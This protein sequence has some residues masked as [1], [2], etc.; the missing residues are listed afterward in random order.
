MKPV[1]GV[2]LDHRTWRG[3]PAEKT[4]YEK[5]SFYDKAAE[6]CEVEVLYFSLPNVNLGKNR[7]R[8]YI[9]SDDS[10]QLVCRP[11]PDIIHNRSMSA[12][13]KLRKRLRLMAK[14]RVVYN[15]R[16]RYSKYTIHQ[17]LQK[18]EELKNHLPFTLLLGKKSLTKMLEEYP[19]IYVKPVSSSI[20]KGI[21]RLDKR[22]EHSWIIRSSRGRKVKK[23]EEVLRSLLKECRGRTY[24]LQEAIA[25]AE[26]QGNPF[27]IRVSVQK[28]EGG[29]WVV[30][31]M[32]GKVAAIGSHV[33]NVA[34]GG[35]VK[36]CEELF[37]ESGLDMKKT[38]N[39]IE[40]V[41][42]LIADHLDENL[43]SLSDVGLDIG[44]DQNGKPYFIEMNGRDLR[45]SFR[46]GKMEEEWYRTYENPIRYGA[47]LCYRQE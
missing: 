42:L 22:G 45:Y 12:D 24:L 39:E 3:I 27:D 46:N 35:K 17:I 43:P 11:I 29:Q 41:S 28:G 6:Q 9:R 37:K 33:T 13:P 23:S 15:L 4:G 19:S 7:V 21:I 32:V 16:T 36:S 1:I 20:G 8:A 40:R 2:L 5:V 47:Y 38:V 34:R 18:K 31:G 44:V 30:T 26:Y 14:G 25:L 10:F